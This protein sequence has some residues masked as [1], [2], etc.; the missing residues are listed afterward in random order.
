[1]TPSKKIQRS[2]CGLPEGYDGLFVI[3]EPNFFEEKCSPTNEPIVASS[4]AHGR[5]YDTIWAFVWPTESRYECCGWF[6]FNLLPDRIIPD[7][8]DVHRDH[9]SRGIASAVYRYI[10][11][12]T[13]IMVVPSLEQSEAARALWKSLAPN[14][15]HL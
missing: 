13:E 11:S 10:S 4:T 8:V 2:I 9:Q 1:M 5:E 12:V 15:D 14:S 3:V 7:N 6:S